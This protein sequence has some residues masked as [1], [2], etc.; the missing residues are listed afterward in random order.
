MIQARSDRGVAKGR[1]ALDVDAEVEKLLASETGGPEPRRRPRAPRGGPPAGGRPQRAPAAP[2][3]GA[4]RRR[5]GDRSPAPGAREPRSIRSSA[6]EASDAENRVTELEELA[7]VPGHL[8]QPADRGAWWWSTTRPRSTRRSST[9]RPTRA[10]IGFGSRTRSRSTR[11]SATRLLEE[12]QTRYHPGSA[13]SVSETALEQGDEE[14]DEDED[15]QD[16]GREDIE[17]EWWSRKGRRPRTSRSRTRT[18]TGHPERA[19]RRSRRPLLL[20]KGGHPRLHRP[21]LRSPRPP[22][23]LR[24]RRRPVVGVSP[25]TVTAQRKFADKYRLD[26]TLLADENHEVADLY[27]VWGEKKMY[28][29][30]YM[31]VQRATFL[32]DPDGKV[33]K[34][35]PR[36]RRRRTTRSC[37]RRS[38]SSPPPERLRLWRQG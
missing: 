22:R 26:F 9:W 32:I 23:R 16:P 31:G 4:A 20:P 14:L 33:A 3:Q 35:F 11:N 25:D 19:A 8:L 2:G 21:G 37:S 18:A 12:F 17:G 7:D 1:E 6:V 15:G 30:T 24:G 10:R 13:G 34:V 29:K 28:G 27:G 38:A 5:E 36:S